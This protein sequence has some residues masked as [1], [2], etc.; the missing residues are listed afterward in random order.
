MKGMI[1]T[2]LVEFVEEKFG[3]DIADAMLEAS[4]LENKG[5]YTQ[6]ANY[7]FEEL[8]A[9]V[10]RLAE[11]TGNPAGDLIEVYG[12]HLF[13]RIVG[14]YPP[15][16]AHF[17]SSLPFIAKVDTFIHPEVKKLYPDADLPSFNVISL[18]DHELIIDYTSNK[19]LMPL[20]R[21]LMLGAADHFGETIE[22]IEDDTI[23][24]AGQLARFTVRLN[25]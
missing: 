1:F 6:A 9:I 20:A 19:P 21:G 23:H 24:D 18:S 11:I 22:I 3:F 12:R 14:L 13:G 25:G 4:L 2:E 7:P 15:M 8:V 16:I 17:S 10:T 5:A